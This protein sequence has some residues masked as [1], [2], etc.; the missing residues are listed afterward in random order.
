MLYGVLGADPGVGTYLAAMS[1]SQTAGEAAGWSWT[2]EHFAFRA[3]RC[4]V[5]YSSEIPAF[6]EDSRG[7]LG[8]YG[9]LTGEGTFCSERS[10]LGEET[11]AS[12]AGTPA[13]I[14]SARET[15]G[16]SQLLRQLDGLFVFVL[17]DKKERRLHLARGRIGG[18]PLY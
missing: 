5:S 9:S 12:I 15:P 4:V 10:A 3:C 2:G 13:A 7:V 1:L 11:L 8:A 17:W 16:T 18:A 6:V 14:L